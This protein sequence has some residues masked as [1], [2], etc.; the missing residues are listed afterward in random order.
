M[1]DSLVQTKASDRA[2]GQDAAVAKDASAAADGP[3]VA[4]AEIGLRGMFTLTTEDKLREV[5]FGLEEDI[6]GTDPIWTIHFDLKERD[7]ETD[8]FTDIVALDVL[9]DEEVLRPAAAAAAQNGLTP[10]QSAHAL[11]PAADDAKGTTTGDVDPSD[12]HDTVKGTLK[13]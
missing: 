13:K 7:N 5:I 4:G 2:A 1:S 11:G 8:D 9:V 3:T 12:A 10:P 6:K